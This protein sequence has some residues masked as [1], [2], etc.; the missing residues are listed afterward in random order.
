MKK[1]ILLGFII[2]IFILTAVRGCK[3]IFNNEAKAQTFKN[4]LDIETLP[5]KDLVKYTYFNK[6]VED[7]S[8]ILHNGVYYRE[9]KMESKKIFYKSNQNKKLVKIYPADTFYQLNPLNWVIIEHG[10]STIKDFNYSEDFSFKIINEAN[11]DTLY[12]NYDDSILNYWD[13]TWSAAHDDTQGVS[14]DPSTDRLRVNA[15]YS[16]GNGYGV[17]RAALLFDTDLGG[18]V[19]TSSD[20]ILYV[21]AV[22]NNDN[23]GLDYVVIT[24]ADFDDP[25]TPTIYDFNNFGDTDFPA[26]LSNQNDITGYADTDQ[27]TFNL[28]ATG[29]TYI[30]TSGDTQF[31]MRMGHD[32]VDQA[33]DA[34]NQILFY[35]SETAG[36]TYD[37]YLLIEYEETPTST[38]EYQDY[39]YPGN[40]Y[41]LIYSLGKG[42]MFLAGLFIIIALVLG[43]FTEFMAKIT[44]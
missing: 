5:D 35:S 2:F 20:L 28:N 17:S 44:K 41:E 29:T 26:Q 19:A 24:P 34:A 42:M 6:Y 23:D 7:K 22:T 9:V 32:V 12:P 30:N 11:A 16:A 36:T 15:Q 3:N 31:G 43:L 10:T 38:P 37:P 18:A 25:S 40:D 39:E 1:Y 21:M 14:V 13:G 33:P 27:M 4:Y 8:T